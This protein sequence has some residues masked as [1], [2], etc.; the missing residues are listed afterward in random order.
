MREIKFRA[1]H[2]EQGMY[3]VY[4]FNKKF[5]FKNDL[6]SP[7][8]LENIFPIQ[9]C[10]LMQFTGLKD[11]NGV[12][13]YEGDL[14]EFNGGNQLAVFFEGGSFGCVDHFLNFLSFCDWNM[15]VAEVVGNIYENKM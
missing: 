9:E 13:I 1:Y 2:K 14:L 5:V 3:D 4:G 12:D 15:S 8:A 7:E 6:N 11:K 10:I